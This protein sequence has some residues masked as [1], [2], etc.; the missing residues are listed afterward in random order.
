MFTNNGD[1]VNELFKPSLNGI[2][3]E[4]YLMQI[5]DRWGN[6]IY[7]TNNYQEGWDGTNNG[8]MINQDIYSY[9]IS[10]MQPNGEE[11]EHKGHITLVK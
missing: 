1:N 3:K 10:Y 9:E 2:V 4:S 6:L 11:K 8:K 7:S 5:Y